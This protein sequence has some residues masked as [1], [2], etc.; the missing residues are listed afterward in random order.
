MLA[1]VC[2][3]ISLIN[4]VIVAVIH[5][6]LPPIP[7]LDTTQGNAFRLNSA[8]TNVSECRKKFSLETVNGV[9]ELERDDY[10]CW[11]SQKRLAQSSMF[12]SSSNS[13]QEYKKIQKTISVSAI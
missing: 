13:Y 10:S 1:H 8:N 9:R 7:G 12:E 5:A 3:I 11:C 4:V 6:Q 2:Q